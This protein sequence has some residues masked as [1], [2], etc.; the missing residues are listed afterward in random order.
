[1]ETKELVADIIEMMRKEGFEY[2]PDE[3]YTIIY[4]DHQQKFTSYRLE[5][6][7]IT[8]TEVMKEETDELPAL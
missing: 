7:W 5:G 3:S 8:F 1:M 6:F 2:D 4:R